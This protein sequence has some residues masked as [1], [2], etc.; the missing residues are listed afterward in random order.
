MQKPL[1]WVVDPDTLTLEERIA[2]DSTDLWTLTPGSFEPHNIAL[3]RVHV[4]RTRRHLENDL[5]MV[6]TWKG[7]FSQVDAIQEHYREKQEYKV[8]GKYLREY[9]SAVPGRILQVDES[10]ADVGK[11][12]DPVTA[13]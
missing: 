12:N 6:C 3:K 1:Q 13:V 7:V 2:V 5:V 9:S 8:V 11:L 10:D 4:L